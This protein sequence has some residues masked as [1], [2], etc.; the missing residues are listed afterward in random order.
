MVVSF[1]AISSEAKQVQFPQPLLRGLL[2][3][4]LLVV[5][6]ELAPVCPCFSC[7][8]DP[9]LGL[10]LQC[11]PSLGKLDKHICYP[12]GCSAFG[13]FCCQGTLLAHAQL[14]LCLDTQILFWRAAPLPIS[15]SLY[16]CRGS[17]FPSAGFCIFPC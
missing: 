6:A 4:N 10:V 11:H 16:C 8:G 13:F 12:P 2:P 15:P 9:K 3:S 14:A 5:S 7:I 1:K 17:S